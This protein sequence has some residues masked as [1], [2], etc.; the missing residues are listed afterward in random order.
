MHTIREL[1]FVIDDHDR[2]TVIEATLV[3]TTTD[4]SFSMETTYIDDKSREVVKEVLANR[5]VI[6]TK[7]IA[8][9]DD[10][11]SIQAFADNPFVE[12]LSK[13]S[14]DTI[15]GSRGVEMPEIL[16][17]LY[18]ISL[19]GAEH[20]T[21]FDLQECYDF[22]AKIIFYHTNGSIRPNLYVGEVGHPEEMRAFSVRR[23]QLPISHQQL[24]QALRNIP[25]PPMIDSGSFTPDIEPDYFNIWTTTDSQKPLPPALTIHPKPPMACIKPSFTES[26]LTKSSGLYYRGRDYHRRK[27]LAE[28]TYDFLWEDLRKPLPDSKLDFKLVANKQRKPVGDLGTSF[29]MKDVGDAFALTLFPKAQDSDGGYKYG[30]PCP[31]VP[32][33]DDLPLWAEYPEEL[34]ATIPMERRSAQSGMPFTLN[35]LAQKIAGAYG[36]DADARQSPSF[37]FIPSDHGE[38]LLK[39]FKSWLDYIEATG[40]L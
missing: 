13:L 7:L 14:A 16:Q 33:H 24:E 28:N 6:L 29:H 39:F 9:K 38:P 5:T 31:Y 27:Q 37:Q 4:T 35:H 22:V 11:G 19:Q 21:G 26:L 30:T 10:F 8:I 23:K 36:Y 12:R 15:W 32:Y 17:Y 18:E 1:P 3:I 40:P 25:W 34:T 2:S 20:L